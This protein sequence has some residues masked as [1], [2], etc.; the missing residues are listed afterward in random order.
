MWEGPTEHLH[1]QDMVVRVHGG[2][3]HVQTQGT[4]GGPGGLGQVVCGYSVVT[5]RG[6][7][8]ELEMKLCKG[9]PIPCHG[10]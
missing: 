7:R 8:Q 4:K 9:P 6:G 3:T 1:R 5:G 10:I 2:K